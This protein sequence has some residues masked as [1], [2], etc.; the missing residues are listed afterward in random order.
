MKIVKILRLPRSAMRYR[1]IGLCLL[2]CAVL[3]AGAVWFSAK[4]Y[5]QLPEVRARRVLDG[6]RS[7]PPSRLEVF[8]VKLGLWRQRHPMD[9]H[10]AVNE[11]V[12][13]GPSAE[14]ALVEALSDGDANV[15]YATVEALGLLRCNGAIE[16]LAAMA[17]KGGVTPTPFQ[18]RIGLALCRLGDHRGVRAALR[19]APLPRTASDYPGFAGWTYGQSQAE[20][21]S[22]L[23]LLVSIGPAAVLP[24]VE[25][26]FAASHETGHEDYTAT[27]MLR[28]LLKRMIEPQ[29]SA[30]AWDA[31]RER[32]RRLEALRREVDPACQPV[33]VSV[34]RNGHVNVR[35]RAAE[36]LGYV[37]NA[38]AAGELRIAHDLALKA[39]EPGFSLAKCYADAV[40]KAIQSLGRLGEP[41]VPVLLALSEERNKGRAWSNLWDP[42]YRALADSDSVTAR[43]FLQDHVLQGK[44]GAIEALVAMA[45][46]AGIEFLLAQLATSS[47]RVEIAVALGNADE[48]RALPTLLELT[49][50]LPSNL[51]CSVLEAIGR[52]GDRQAVPAL[53]RCLGSQKWSV[54]QSS[55]YALGLIADPMA[56][57]AL[58]EVMN[59]DPE[60]QVREAAA[61]A[62]AKMSGPEAEHYLARA[63]ASPGS[64]VGVRQA[65]ARGLGK[66][67]RSDFLP[68]L[69]AALGDPAWEVRVAVVSALGQIGDPQALPAVELLTNDSSVRGMADYDTA[70]KRLRNAVTSATSGSN[71]GQ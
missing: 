16:Q 32:R 29:E 30:N 35:A 26:S 69:I 19:C 57:G 59:N 27:W 4:V 5:C 36:F 68:G 17:P 64:R 51:P 2:L 3:L 38:E 67:G 15:L 31:R 44:L 71:E 70:V 40:T 50:P 52:L 7:S 23:E 33:L 46:P 48:K 28:D 54:R 43:E 66:A 65:A 18:A 42:P 60:A 12:Q 41:G 11:I 45:D 20:G 49:D 21:E 13:I 24:L 8:C 14:K 6:L 53:V 10:Q 1:A 61:Y 55:C 25:E 56:A 63:L 34:L 9:I 39:R 58:A 22:F 62:I 37:G 47:R